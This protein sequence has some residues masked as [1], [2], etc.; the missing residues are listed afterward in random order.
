[1]LTGNDQ[2]SQSFDIRF[3]ASASDGAT[4]NVQFFY[5]SDSSGFNGTAIACGATVAAAA[6]AAANSVYLPLITRM[7]PPPPVVPT[8]ATCRW[9]TA[10]VPN[11]TYY[12]YGVAANG[13]SSYR[14]YSQTPVVVTH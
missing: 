12:V 5:D 3:E 1:M 2:A 13:P 11:G 6:P 9:N 10:G 8:G 7:V 4:P 14:V